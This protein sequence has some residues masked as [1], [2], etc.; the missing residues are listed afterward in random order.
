MA[1]LKYM[2][3]D[4][5]N[6]IN[7]N[8]QTPLHCA[9]EN[10]QDAIVELL[11]EASKSGKVVI[12]PLLS[13]NHKRTPLHL[14]VNTGK[15]ELVQTVLGIPQDVNQ[16][17]PN[18]RTPLH[19]AALDDKSDI[20]SLLL[21]HGADPLLRDKENKTALGLAVG[22][23]SLTILDVFLRNCGSHSM[24]LLESI[25]GE[26]KSSLLHLAAESGSPDAVVYLLYK[27]ANRIAR[28]SYGCT[29]IHRASRYGDLRVLR[30][31]SNTDKSL[32]DSGNSEGFTP[33]H[34]AARCDNVEV[35]EFLLDKGAVLDKCTV[36]GVTPLLLAAAFGAQN[37]VRYLLCLKVDYMKKDQ[38]GANIIHLAVGHVKT[39]RILAEILQPRGVFEGLIHDQ[40]NEGSTPL[41]YAADHGGP[42]D[43][44]F[45]FQHE[46]SA[47]AVNQKGLTPLHIAASRGHVQI[48]AKLCSYALPALNA[49]DENGRTPLHLACFYGQPE[50]V[51]NLLKYGTTITEDHDGRTQLHFAAWNG[52]VACMK[53]LLS[54]YPEELNKKDVEKAT[55]LHLAVVANHAV[56]T[57]YLLDQNACLSDNKFG[58]N[59]LDV[60]LALEKEDSAAVI[61][62][63]QRWRESMKPL[64]SNA[65]SQLELMVEKMP[66]LALVVMDS[67]VTSESYPKSK[68]IFDFQYMQ[69][70]TNTKCPVPAMASLRLLEAMVKFRRTACMAHSLC[71]EFLNSKWRKFG[72]A[73]AFTNITV[74][75]LFLLVLMALVIQ[76][77]V[78]TDKPLSHGVQA[79]RLLEILNNSMPENRT[80]LTFSEKSEFCYGKFGTRMAT[81]AFAIVALLKEMVPIFYE[82]SNYFKLSNVSELLVYILTLV[83]LD[84]FGLI[85][86]LFNVP[87][88]C[89]KVVWEIGA[90]TVFYAWL[91]FLLNLRRVPVLGIYIVMITS[92]VKTL[93]KVVV[94]VS[95][96]MLG[97][98]LSFFMLMNTTPLFVS[99]ELSLMKV[100]VMFL[101]DLAYGDILPPQRI[102]SDNV[103]VYQQ[104]LKFWY[105]QFEFS[106]HLPSVMNIDSTFQSNAIRVDDQSLVAFPELS[107]ALFVIFLLLMP[108]VVLNM[109]IGLAVG[110][111]AVV[112]S[113]AALRQIRMQIKF[114][115]QLEHALPSWILSRFQ[116]LKS[117]QVEGDRTL[118]GWIRNI[119]KA[120]DEPNANEVSKTVEQ[121][122][123][124]TSSH[125]H[126]DEWLSSIQKNLD[127]QDAVIKLLASRVKHERE[128]PGEKSSQPS[129]QQDDTNGTDPGNEEEQQ[130]TQLMMT[131]A[132]SDMLMVASEEPGD[133]MV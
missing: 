87:V 61:V 32:F 38:N 54:A 10:E 39:L 117:V 64:G 118:H 2:Q 3:R 73:V 79:R 89:P 36:S 88:E 55:P 57:A 103:A 108:V 76:F 48:V 111:I 126:L 75:L 62:K 37:V 66:N 8:E 9:L 72:A 77:P 130:Q 24:D 94:V 93:L 74:Y 5:V 78:Y 53:E 85:L 42:S 109:L 50:V 14:A 47:V 69:G 51:S 67:C 56:M 104:Q 45:F 101:G 16:R 106:N 18:D 84:P 131:P 119:I 41:H 33:L 52:S 20:A 124:I 114:L 133:E 107:Y 65:K 97:F 22:T 31:F 15:V 122:T 98:G 125:R 113:D 83:F 91:V 128:Q 100:I 60:A 63:H 7:E 1:C 17:G 4:D 116:V 71:V 96:F 68:R 23:G 11:C 6:E 25:S 95:L 27:N 29:V 92:M 90:V 132:E 121:L 80:N 123:A 35:V 110:D 99:G 19:V 129:I 13:D 86:N 112:Q 127:Q 70:V 43:V 28:D 59:C 34:E 40:D 81:V 115:V 46:A 21:Q 82:K 30:Q 26:D 105:Q 58:Q 12:N 102:S 120:A 49:T 44:T